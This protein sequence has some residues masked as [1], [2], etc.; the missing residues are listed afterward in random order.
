MKGRCRG[1]AFLAV[2]L[3][4][5]TGAPP[6]RVLPPPQAEPRWLFLA[7]DAVPYDLV[8]ELTDPGRGGSALFQGFPPPA[9]LISSF[10]STTSVALTGILEPFALPRPP[11]YEA[12]FFD[13]AK[14]AV[15]GGGPVSYQKI[16]F[17]WRS[18]F[19]W[20][21]GNPITRSFA[22]AHPVKSSRREVRWVLE[23][24]LRSPEPVFHGY[25][26]VTDG[27]AHLQG[28]RSLVPA[29]ETLDR[30]LAALRRRYPER[31]FYAVIYS[32]HGIDG[33][34]PLVNVREGVSRALAAGGFRLAQRLRSSRDAVMVP[35]GLV[36]SL[37]IY[38]LPGHGAEAARLAAPVPGVDLCAAHDGDGVLVVS[39]R[40]EARILTRPAD[41]EA[42]EWSYRPV[43]GDLG[44]DP[45][46]YLPLLPQV[47]AGSPASS[48]TFYP[49]R[50]WFAATRDHRYPDALYRLSRTFDLVE[51]PASAACSLE[52]GF[53]FG[54]RATE[55]AAWLSTG[56][57]RW[58]HGALTRAASLGF[59]LSDAPGWSPPPALRFDQ[60][61][62]SFAPG[63]HPRLSFAPTS[64]QANEDTGCPQE[65]SLETE[66]PAT[67][68]R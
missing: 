35:F 13:R 67:L 50:D 22:T 66:K 18:F 2:L 62:A 25:V 10:P 56:R 68:R 42:R 27:A 44:G 24:F 48:Q 64:L 17:A 5:C 20:R 38:T 21:F 41:G 52:P 39:R 26:A 34:L 59:L 43:A 61:L 63:Q 8:A 46:G 15:R 4:A 31:P 9:P 11:G 30:G 14:N 16:P 28:P 37:E 49:D 57:L 47:A 53:M 3:A 60:A 58:T 36:S 55:W 51:N 12:R 33:G 29:L 54:A 19:T 40:G 32:D 45:L 6:P 23:R 1:W 65:P 7:L